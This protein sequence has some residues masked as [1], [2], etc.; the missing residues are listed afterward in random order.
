MAETAENIQVL[1]CTGTGGI[2]S[3][4][5]LVADAFEAE[6]AKHGVAAKVG[7]RCDVKKTGCRGLCANDVLVDILLP[8]QQ[9]VTYDFVTPELVPQIVEEHVLGNAPV[10]KKVAGKYY[11]DFLAKQQRIIFSRCGTID[12]ES[13][14]DFLAHRGFTG[15]QKAV[16]MTPEQVIEEVKKSG[17]RG[18]GGGGFPTGTKW[19]FCRATPGHHKYLIC[20]ADEGD[21]GAFMDRSVLEGD[22]Y[23]LIE[24][25]M[26][27]A[28]AIG[29]DFAYVYCRAE[30][31]LAIKRLQKAID[32]CYER[33]I[34]GE[35]CMGLG[36][37]LDMRIKAGAGAFVCG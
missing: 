33:G 1:I 6:F 9:A 12:A 37:K 15:L 27:G 20:N 28:Y 2:A 19:S 3:G 26:I 7:K 22:P 8:G 29:C 10:E 32:T 34:L 30:Y 18:R 23:G 25:M 31:P 21:P 16:T 13:I 5:L 4:S 36:F 11:T 17:L 35:N 24:G 14:D